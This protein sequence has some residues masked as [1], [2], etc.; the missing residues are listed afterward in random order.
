M[1]E[2]FPDSIKDENDL[3]IYENFLKSTDTHSQSD[4]KEYLN[5]SKGKYIKAES[6]ICGRMFPKYGILTD[7]GTDYIILK[8]AQNNSCTAIK[9]SDIRYITVLGKK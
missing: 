5:K 4:L 7:I 8:A 2:K 9:L 1:Y 6:F 3:E